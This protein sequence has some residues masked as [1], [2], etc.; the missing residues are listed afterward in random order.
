MELHFGAGALFGER[1][2]VAAS[3]VTPQQFG[4][5]QD[6][7]IDWDFTNKELWG[8]FQMPVAI[9]RG[10]GKITGK[11]KFARVF[12]SLYNDMFFGLSTATGTDAVALFE[13]GTIA[14]STP[15]VVTVA[16]SVNWFQD[17]GVYYA[18][19]VNSGLAFSRVTTP[20]TTAQYSVAAGVYTFN[21]GDKGLAVQISYKWTNAAAG[22]K[23]VITNRLMGETPTWRATFSNNEGGSAGSLPMTLELNACTSQKISFPTRLDDW[24]IEEVDFN[25]YADAS[26]T[27]GTLSMTE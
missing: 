2:D 13:N 4:V 8:Q 5:L 15:F 1:T 12:G 11:A 19:G 3:T 10:Q 17:L 14:G 27:I 21:T 6:V 26:G 22:K 7:T 9:A 16:N 24:M 23:I 18:S 20:T 25:S